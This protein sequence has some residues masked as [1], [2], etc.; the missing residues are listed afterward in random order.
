MP[1]EFTNKTIEELAKQIPAKEIYGDLA[2]PATREVG[3]IFADLVKT[4]RLALAPIQ[5]FGAMQDRYKNF[6]DRTVRRVPEERRISPAPQ[7]LGPVLEA[8]KYEPEGTPIDEMFSALLSSA[9]DREK[10]DQAHPA[11]VAIIKQ[12]SSDEAILLNALLGGPRRFNYRLPYDHKAQRF[13]QSIT[14]FD[15][16]PM[17]LLRSAK[18]FDLYMAHLFN[19]GLA[20]YYDWQEQKPEFESTVAQQIDGRIIQAQRVQ[21]GVKVFKELKLTDW[22]TVLMDA[23]RSAN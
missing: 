3:E 15:D 19:L 23:C 5:L 17:S 10:V 20:A 13:G 4:L 11:F 22:G 8:I 7:I 14:E 9:M 12:L 6:L 21:V 2:S 18:S 1:D 16:R